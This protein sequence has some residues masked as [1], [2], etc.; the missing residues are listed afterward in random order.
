MF[1]EIMHIV[2][3]RHAE[4]IE[5]QNGTVQGRLPGRLSERGKR[6][7]RELGLKLGP[8]GP[9]DQIIASD[10]DRAKET[11]MLLSGE[12]PSCPVRC[13]DRLR[14][15][16]Y[17]SLEGK[18]ALHLKRRLVE[19]KTDLRRLPIPDG[20]SPEQVVAR[21]ADFFRGL[22]AEPSERNVIVVTHA[23]VIQVILQ[24]VL[25]MPGRKI[26]NCEAFR[27]S[28]TREQNMQVH[29]I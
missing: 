12:L 1:G 18:P 8:Y 29:P 28:I 26:G 13:D 7:A 11:A 25:G 17:G 21:I 24:D 20:E 3:V 22:M 9:F 5:N 23:G 19:E 14:E 27:I 6:Q 2:V 16:H 4:T 15:R 10:L